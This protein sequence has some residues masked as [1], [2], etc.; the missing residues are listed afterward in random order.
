MWKAV[1]FINPFLSRNVAKERE[2]M[3][4]ENKIWMNVNWIRMSWKE[5]LML[6]L[7][8][9]PEIKALPKVSSDMWGED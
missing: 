3:E 7:T 4:R 2:E 5:L 1:T 9:N 8:D 6:Q